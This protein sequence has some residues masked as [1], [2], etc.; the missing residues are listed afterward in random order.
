MGG[1]HSIDRVHETRGLGVSLM[2]HQ[3]PGYL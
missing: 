1:Y 3:V 2:Y